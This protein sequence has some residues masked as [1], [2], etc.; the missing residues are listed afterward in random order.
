ML[1]IAILQGRLVA[2]PEPHHTPNG[3]TVTKFTVAVERSY[4][5]AGEERQADFIDIVAWRNTAEFV[6][7]YFRKGQTIA[8]QGSIQ[9][10]T[11]TDRDGNNRKAVEVVADQVHFADS[12]RQEDDGEDRAAQARAAAGTM[13]EAHGGFIPLKSAPAV[14]YD[15]A[16]D[17]R[18]DDDLPF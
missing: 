18:L 9:T 13:P 12:K 1:N 14:A 7:K 11:Y 10:R 5:K 8:L 2:D 16:D 4:V 6:C 17:P 3:V 15:T